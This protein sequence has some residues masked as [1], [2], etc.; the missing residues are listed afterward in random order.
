VSG[1]INKLKKDVLFRPPEVAEEVE[2]I[3][4]D[5]NFYPDFDKFGKW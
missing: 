3:S 2:N 1:V 4:A 5:N